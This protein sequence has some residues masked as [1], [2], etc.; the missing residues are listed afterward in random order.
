M[1]SLYAHALLTRD[2][3]QVFGGREPDVDDA[4]ANCWAD[5]DLL[6]VRVGRVQEAAVLRHGNDSH[7]V[8]RAAGGQ[9]RALEWVDGN[10]DRGCVCG[11]VAYLLTDVEHGRLVALALADDDRPANAQRTERAT[12][13][14][15]GGPV[16]AIVI[17]EPDE[18][19][20]G[21]RRRLRDPH[22]LKC[23]I[24]VHVQTL[25]ALSRSLLCG[26]ADDEPSQAC[27]DDAVVTHVRCRR[28]LRPHRPSAIHKLTRRSIFQTLR[29][30]RIRK[31]PGP[32]PCM[33]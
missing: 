22:D 12:H 33:S 3:R 29:P 23:Q 30:S 14:L 21:E 31:S 26:S 13:R 32:R 4:V 11:S 6:H 7:R 25:S 28:G 5:R 27:A 2:G 1:R 10:V 18:A 17:A 16:G 9:V 24:P 20:R 8:A 19:R 15:R